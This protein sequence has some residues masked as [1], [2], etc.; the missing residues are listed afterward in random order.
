MMEEFF[1][2]K[3]LYFDWISEKIFYL[4]RKKIINNFSDDLYW[5]VPH[6]RWELLHVFV[7]I[8]EDIFVLKPTV[9][10]LKCLV[11]LDKI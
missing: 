3:S 11:I 5:R 1:I 4:R 6:K 10:E 8:W 2:R 9:P 7:S